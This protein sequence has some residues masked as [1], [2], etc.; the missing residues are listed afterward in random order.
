[1]PGN[2][3]SNY[4]ITLSKTNFDRSNPEYLGKLRS[5]FVGTQFTLFDNG[6]NPHRAKNGATVRKELCQIEYVT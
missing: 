2:K 5:N 4:A 1:M 6:A 3:S